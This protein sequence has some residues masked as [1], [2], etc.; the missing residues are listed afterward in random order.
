MLPVRCIG[1]LRFT[2]HRLENGSIFEM[3][4]WESTEFGARALLLKS[5][6]SKPR[7]EIERLAQARLERLVTHARDNSEYWHDKL[8][9]VPNSDFEIAD[10]PTSDKHELMEH[11]DYAVTVDDVRRDDAEAFLDDESNIGKYFRDKY[12]LSHTSGTQGRPLVVVQPKD[13]IELLFALQVSR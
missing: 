1:V 13:N 6:A 10:L 12:A 5:A 11:F 7:E 2:A 8:T 4:F 9:G 3:E